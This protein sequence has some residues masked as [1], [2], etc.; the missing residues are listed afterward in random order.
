[1]KN[2]TENKI[3]GF[4]IKSIYALLPHEEARHI[5]EAKRNP[6]QLVAFSTIFPTEREAI[7]AMKKAGL[8]TPKTVTHQ[9]VDLSVFPKAKPLILL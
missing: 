2:N 5:E 8:W 3:E 4:I 9:I 1:M 7:K 6:D